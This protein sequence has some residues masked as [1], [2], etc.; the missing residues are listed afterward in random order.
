[1][2]LIAAAGASIPSSAQPTDSEIDALRREMLELRESY[3]RRIVSLEQRLA[4]LEARTTGRPPAGPEP[5]PGAELEAL[6]AAAREAAGEQ[7]HPTPSEVHPVARRASTGQ[8]RMLNRLN[9]EISFTGDVVALSEG[10]EN[11]LDAR[12]FELDFQAQLDPFSS[13]KW[14]LAFADDEV[15]I[16]EGYVSYAG[17]ANGLALRAGKMRQTFGPLNRTHLHALPQVDFPLVLETYF[18]EEGLA[19]TGLSVEWLVPRPWASANELTLQVTDGSSDAFGGQSFDDLAVL[20]HVKNYW[21]LS[22]STWFEWGL[23]GIEG[24]P[25]EGRDTRVLG[26]DFTLHWQPPARAK[27]REITWRTEALFSERDDLLGIEQEAWGGYTYLEGLVRRNLSV[28]LRYDNVE[29]PLAPSL[30]V[31]AWEPYISWWQS[32]YVRLRAAWQALED[33]LR[34][35]TDHRFRFQVT[36][37]AGPHKHEAY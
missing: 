23:S 33:D 21:D 37:A 17:L 28:G 4:T 1:L 11:D 29:D 13:T 25:E 2:T 26:T 18:A 7:A 8:E 22:P 27:Y 9:P 15:E 31:E 19:Q 6:R 14:T 35:G 32:E 24:S 16:E 5:T 30:T 36:W 34:R 3:E 12:E 10:G 20:L